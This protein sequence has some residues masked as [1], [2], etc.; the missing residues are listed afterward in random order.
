MSH[1]VTRQS[2]VAYNRLQTIEHKQARILNVCYLYGLEHTQSSMMTSAISVCYFTRLVDKF[3]YN[4][5]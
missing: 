1:A 5:I 4:N 2:V 3:G